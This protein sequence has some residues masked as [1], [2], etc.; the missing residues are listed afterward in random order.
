MGQHENTGGVMTFWKHLEELR[1]HLLRSGIAVMVFGL[2]A[3]INKDFLFSRVILA[4]KEPFFFTNRLFCY[5]AERFSTPALCINSTPLEIINIDMAG[6][7]TTH[8]MISIT[9]GIILAIPYLVW[10]IWRF[11]KPGLT[12][13]ELAASKGAVVVISGLFLSGVLFAYFFI[14]PLSINFLGGYQVSAMVENQIALRS[15]I[16]LVTTLSLA[17]GLV[18]ELPVFVYFLSR[19]GILTPKALRKNRKI[20]AIL[21]VTLSAII[22]PPDVISQIL[23]SI[24]LY[25]LYEVSIKVA[26]RVERNKLRE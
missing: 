24:P 25:L 11:I 2:L 7:F 3:F 16:S 22:T 18:F 23:V 20:A 14:V 12:K 13:K 5:L 9:A 26:D 19:A 10:E 6:Q 21:L 8:V 17:T 15:Y 1:S 4:P